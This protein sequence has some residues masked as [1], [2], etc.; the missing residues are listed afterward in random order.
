M[1]KI[2]IITGCTGQDGALL[3][4]FLLEKE[5]TVVGIDRRTSSKTDWRIRELGLYDNP[6]FYL[7]SGDLTDLGS[8]IRCI[9]KWQPDE[10]Y[11]L[12]A[13]S[14]VGESWNTPSATM[15][16]NAIGCI[17]CLEAIRNHAPS[18]RF[19]QASSSEMFGGANRKEVLNEESIFYPRSPYGVSK[20]AAHWSTINYRES[21]DMFCCC[22]ILFNHESEYRGIE[23]VTRKITDGVA[24]IHLGKQ[25][26]IELGNLDSCRDWGYAPDYVEG[27]WLMLQQ[28]EPDD[29]VLATG[30]SR[31][32][33]DFVLSALSH[34]DCWGLISDFV[35]QNPKFIRPAEVGHLL[36]DASK[37]R[38]KLGWE[39]KTE[40]SDM[41]RIMIE[42][43]IKRIKNET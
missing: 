31:S 21:F 16:I 11:N 12:G 33:K 15:H 37:A 4:K 24:R 29:Y 32:I 36:G 19:Y 18:C 8:I 22:G 27:M 43:D 35:V 17:N 7:A 2:A 3:S 20:V 34:A 30:Q 1:S 9:Q 6:K 40:F 23:F 41:V 13:M 5:Y 25:S 28:D 26:T 10:F 42:K 14:F 38:E 39:A